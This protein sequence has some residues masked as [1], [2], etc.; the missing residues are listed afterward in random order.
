M[1]SNTTSDEKDKIGFP[2]LLLLTLCLLPVAARASGPGDAGQ[3]ARQTNQ[4]IV[5]QTQSRTQSEEPGIL[6]WLENL[7][8]S[9]IRFGGPSILSKSQPQVLAA[10]DCYDSGAGIS[11]NGFQNMEKYL[12]AVH[13]S[14]NLGIPF[15]RLKAQMQ[16]GKT[17]HQAIRALRPTANAWIEALKARQQAER[18]LRAS[19]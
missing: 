15:E 10:A 12:A 8:P 14:Q 5:A 11:C 7:L 4:P 2:A 9:G 18:T 1:T 16:E 19:S 3:P 13:A 17:L 6:A